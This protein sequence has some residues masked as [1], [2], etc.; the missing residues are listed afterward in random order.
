MVRVKLIKLPDDT[1]YEFSEEEKNRVGKIFEAFELDFTTETRF[2]LYIEKDKCLWYVPKEFCEVIEEQTI[3]NFV[4]NSKQF[5]DIDLIKLPK[6]SKRKI[7][8]VPD[9][10]V[11]TDR[12]DKMGIEYIIYRDSSPKPEFIEY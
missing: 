7:L 10:S 8:L 2:G 6:P 12:L 11:D 1:N 9:G 5:D 4:D 3:D